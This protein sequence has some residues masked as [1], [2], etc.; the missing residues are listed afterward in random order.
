MKALFVS[1]AV[2]AA[3]S[4]ALAS[5]IIR[6]DLTVDVLEREPYVIWDRITY[7]ELQATLKIR[8]AVE[9]QPSHSDCKDRVGR[10]V[11]AALHLKKDNA[12]LTRLKAVAKGS[13]VKVAYR[14][15]DGLTPQGVIA[16]EFYWLD[17]EPK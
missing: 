13:S 3:G 4:P 12:A 11:K 15:T 8:E 1:L 16:S 17:R 5:S 2:L 14:Y 7:Y 10:E 6:C 9:V